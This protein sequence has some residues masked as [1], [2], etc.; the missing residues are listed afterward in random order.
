MDLAEQLMQI[1][2][3]ATLFAQQDA[4]TMADLIAA[5][6]DGTKEIHH[7]SELVEDVKTSLT[8]LRTHSRADAHSG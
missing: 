7:T 6:G 4:H 8:E 5:L 2:E 3:S 1:V